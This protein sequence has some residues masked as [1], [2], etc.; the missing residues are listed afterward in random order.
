MSESF[1]TNLDE[2]N[3]R[4]TDKNVVA[5]GYEADAIRPSLPPDYYLTNFECFL[6]FV[7]QQ[8]ANLW[9]P[10]ELSIIRRF[11]TLPVMA[12]RLWV[13]LFMRKGPYFRADQIEYAE[14]PEPAF[15]ADILVKS[16]FLCVNPSRDVERQLML[17]RVPELRASFPV[18]IRAKGRKSELVSDICRYYDTAE[19]LSKI[20]AS[21]SVW[22]LMHQT[23]FEQL[24]LCFFGNARQKLSEYVVVEL[25]HITYPSYQIHTQ[26]QSIQARVVLHE[27]YRAAQAAERWASQVDHSCLFSVQCF[28]VS[29]LSWR[30]TRALRLQRARARLLNQVARQLERLGDLEGAARLYR[31]ADRPPGRERL[32]R[33]LSAQGFL[34]EAL[35]QLEHLAQNDPTPEES[36]F[37]WTNKPKILRKLGIKPDVVEAFS[38]EVTTLSLQKDSDFPDARIERRVCS[39]LTSLE[40]HVFHVENHLFRG[41]Y[42]LTLWR[43]LFMSVPD[44]F[45]NPFQRGPADQ[46]SR[47]FFVTRRDSIK[48]RLASF[49]THGAWADYVILQ[50]EQNRGI[51][52]DWIN[53][54]VWQPDFLQ[55]VVAVVPWAIVRRVCER[56]LAYPSAWR[57]GMPDLLVIQQPVRLGGYALLEVKGPGDTLRANQRE[58]LAYFAKWGV[59][60]SVLQVELKA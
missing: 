26:D 17:L 9:L 40:Q 23:L 15:A 28:A 16:G 59:Q 14:I 27:L 30:N 39:A 35:L 1:I 46:F 25:G 41:L 29:L 10:S 20:S 50:A 5:S 2:K 42:G 48:R 45:F 12:R 43:E 54:Q 51:A 22:S 49:E 7:L 53:W 58:W 56:I 55:Q 13:R 21:F 60:A 57:S 36:R 33:V 11:Q 4:I 52:N 8:Y 34:S 24:Q 6:N 32:V 31:L 44:V 47:D 19:I 18:S 3:A 37:V 38:P